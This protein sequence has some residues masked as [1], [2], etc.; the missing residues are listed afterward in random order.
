MSK[1]KN[2]FVYVEVS[3]ADLLYQFRSKPMTH[4]TDFDLKYNRDILLFRL[5]TMFKAL[6][7]R[8]L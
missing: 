7:I 8:T 3:D 5:Y 1:L 2:G 4:Q 6:A